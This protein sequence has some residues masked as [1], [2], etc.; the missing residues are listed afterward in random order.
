MISKELLQKLTNA[1]V[2]YEIAMYGVDPREK[3]DGT[4][5]R[6]RK[7]EGYKFDVIASWKEQLE[8]IHRS[9]ISYVDAVL[10][11]LPGV[12]LVYYK[13]EDSIKA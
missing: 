13:Q 10:Q 11:A 3:L 8:N 5:M 2:M 4:T 12:N 9:K 7:N 1:Y 6:L